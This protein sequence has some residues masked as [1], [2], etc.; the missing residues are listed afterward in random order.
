[1]SA[2]GKRP[3]SN[4][5]PAT[6]SAAATAPGAPGAL[7]A[8]G[9][10]ATVT[11]SW[12]PPAS[13]GGSPIT[14][15]KIYRGT[16]S[17]QL[18]LRTTVPNVLAYTDSGLT[19]GQA[20]YYQV[21]AVNAVGEGARSNEAT[22]TPISGQ[23]VPSAPRAL[24]AVAGDA[25][26]ALTWL[27]PSSDGGSSITNYKIYRGTASGAESLLTTIGNVSSYTDT[28]VTN[29]VTYFYVV[30]A[31][32]GIGEAVPS[33]EVSATPTPG[34]SVPDAPRNLHANPGNA[35]IAPP[36]LVPP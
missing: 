15:Y 27:A 9:G 33:N 36:C 11:L 29:G 4:E 1:M 3:R 6:P 21:S 34:P 20:Y 25:T 23:T 16:V 30:R 2:G 35:T 28:T 26:I 7:G 12:S 8:T 32:N 5:A 24:S 17:G 22:A 18:S 13:D 14:N 10:D 19:N 31:V